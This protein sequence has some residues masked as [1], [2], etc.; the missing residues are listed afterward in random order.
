MY[1]RQ[2]TAR[3]GTHLGQIGAA[4]WPATV[5]AVLATALIGVVCV[6]TNGKDTGVSIWTSNAAVLVAVGG[7]VL[8]G[9]VGSLVGMALY[10]RLWL[11]LGRHNDKA[12]RSSSGLT[13]KQIESHHLASRLAIGMLMEPTKSIAWVCGVLCLFLTAAIVPML[14]YGMD[15]ESNSTIQPTTVTIQ[16]A[17][18]DDRMAIRSGAAGLPDNVTPNVLRAATRALFGA[19]SAFVYKQ[20]NLTGKAT[21]GDIQYADVEC[22][23]EVTPGQVVPTSKVLF[24]R[25]FGRS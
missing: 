13:V 4:I 21:F 19:E 18:L 3:T 16:H 23:I 2:L 17:Q 8:K 9:S 6:T 22:N 25:L 5:G 11:Q 14:Q 12:S 7:I 24:H 20:M 15:I 10:H 1:Y